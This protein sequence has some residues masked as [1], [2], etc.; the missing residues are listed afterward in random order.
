VQQE[1]WKM[2]YSVFGSV[3]S[4]VSL[5]KWGAISIL[6]LIVLYAMGVYTA[7][8][9]IDHFCASIS[10]GEK[11]SDLQAKAQ[12][13]GLVLDGPSVHGDGPTK[14]LWA[15][16]SSD[17]VARQYACR[18]YGSMETNKVVAKQSGSS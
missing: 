8:S 7:T 5:A 4:F 13:A 16:V 11:M 10:E 1:L 15:R 3:M 9:K 12:V 18:I 2:K 6:S 14:H 17:I